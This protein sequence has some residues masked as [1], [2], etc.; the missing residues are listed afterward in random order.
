VQLVVTYADDVTRYYPVPR[1][2]GWRID[3][4]H[5][6]IVIGRGVPRTMIPLD[7]VRAY[8]IERV[9]GAGSDG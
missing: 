8:G 2:G 1:P 7:G 5:R 9:E 6:Q 4:T 3:V